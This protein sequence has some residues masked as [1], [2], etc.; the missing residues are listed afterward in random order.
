MKMFVLR[1]LKLLT[2]CVGVAV[3]GVLIVPAGALVMMIS[4][5]W[6]TTDKVI[7]R[8]DGWKEEK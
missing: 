1:I 2:L 3:M 7:S 8:L 6:K 4:T 5:V